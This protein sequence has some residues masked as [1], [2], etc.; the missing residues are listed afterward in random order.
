M[1]QI[2]IMGNKVTPE[3]IDTLIAWARERAAENPARKNGKGRYE[4]ELIIPVPD[5]RLLKE[6]HEARSGN[7]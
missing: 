5:R 4:A 1:A 7:K 2:I 6:L 3:N